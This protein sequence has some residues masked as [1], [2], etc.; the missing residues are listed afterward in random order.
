MAIHF[1]NKNI[2]DI[3][4]NWRKAKAVYLWSTKIRPEEQ[5][6]ITEYIEIQLKATNGRLEIP[7]NAV[8][9]WLISIDGWS[10]VQYSW[11][12]W[13][14]LTI[15]TWYVADS[16]H[17]VIIKPSNESY[18][19][20]KAFSYENA[21]SNI[22]W[23]LISIIYDWS[24]MGYATSATSTWNY[25]RYMQYRN[26]VNLT[27]APAEIIPDTVTSIWTRFRAYQYI[28][29]SSLTASPIEVMPNTV[30][31][32]GQ[33]FRTYQ[34]GNCT[35]LQIVQPEVLSNSITS[36]PNYYR[37]SQYL[38]CSLL[39]TPSQ[40]QLPNTVTSIWDYFRS[41]QYSNSGVIKSA[42]EVMPNSVTNIGTFFRDGQYSWCT[43]LT[44]AESEVL[45]SAVVSI[46]NF[47]RTGQYSGCTSL[48]RNSDEAQ[49][50][51]NAVIWSNFRLSQ[52]Y[53]ATGLTNVT[54]LATIGGSNNREMQFDSSWN[55]MSVSILG[56]VVDN[57]YQSA[58]LGTAN[59]DNIYVPNDL[60]SSYQN[61]SNWSAVSNL[62][63]GI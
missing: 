12:W 20:A 61:A 55:N 59:V 32:I 6:V 54:I 44:M 58:W 60:L 9:N 25:F 17:D 21:S 56:N 45:S 3:H 14:D 31:S 23:E 1:R 42:E 57:A 53:G 35:S 18:G 36:I 43:S 33:Y 27:S 24:Y 51:S 11:Y 2:K 40:E 4:L 46:W 63:I 26:C 5:P 47:F 37:S 22:R 52:Y 50:N 28:G 48:L 16:L 38:G 10:F 19:W 13:S 62:F 15:W 49:I 8:Y 30:T 29:C 34:Y 39:S 7:V 41:V